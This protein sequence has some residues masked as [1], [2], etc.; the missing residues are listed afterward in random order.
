MIPSI[1]TLMLWKGWSGMVGCVR[2]VSS[3]LR[4]LLWAR[5][6]LVCNNVLSFH[7]C[8]FSVYPVVC[9]HT[10]RH[11]RVC[12]RLCDRNEEA[13]GCSN[14][15]AQFVNLLWLDSRA[16]GGDAERGKSKEALTRGGEWTK[17]DMV[18]RAVPSSQAERSWPSS[19]GHVLPASSSWTSWHVCDVCCCQIFLAMTAN[20]MT[21]AQ[22]NSSAP[23]CKII[24]KREIREKSRMDC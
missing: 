11:A 2:P 16:G 10:S 18:M 13:D 5:G 21:L 23:E 15:N 12:V 14:I 17:G 19:A 7:C 22:I 24:I 1:W 9:A 8:H 4:Q 6:Q 3:E 20:L